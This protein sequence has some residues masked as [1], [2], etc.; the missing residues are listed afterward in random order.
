M[1]ITSV[2]NDTVKRVKKLALK[3]YRDEENA[4][5]L[6]GV[7]PVREAVACGREMGIPV[8]LSG[9]GPTMMALCSRSN[10]NEFVVRSKPVLAKFADWEVHVLEVENHG[11]QVIRT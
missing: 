3:K 8:Y 6:E 2:S 5:L 11:A 9:A 7:K 1:E 4:F 10:A